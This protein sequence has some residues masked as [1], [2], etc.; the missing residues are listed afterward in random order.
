V[1]PLGKCFARGSHPVDQ[2]LPEGIGRA[3]RYNRLDEWSVLPRDAAVRGLPTRFGGLGRDPSGSIL[4]GVEVT[5][6]QAVRVQGVTCE[7]QQLLGE[8]TIRSDVK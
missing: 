7:V 8:G 1:H 4:P 6:S 2:C 5:V 3:P